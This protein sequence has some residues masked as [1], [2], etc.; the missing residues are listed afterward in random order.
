MKVEGEYRLRFNLFEMRK[1]GHP[2]IKLF[3][4]SVLNVIPQGRSRASKLHPF[5]AIHR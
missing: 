2:Y 1:Y 5:E 3:I 4:D